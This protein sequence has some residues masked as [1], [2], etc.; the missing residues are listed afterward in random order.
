MKKIVLLSVAIVLLSSCGRNALNTGGEL[1]GVK[2]ASFSEPA[3]YG[4]VLIK[5]GSFE[6]GPAESDS[7]WGYEAD[8]KGVSFESFWMDETEITNAKYRQFVIWVRDSLIRTRLADPEY[9]G[10]DRFM[11][12]EDRY[13]DPVTPHLDWSR[14]IP[15]RPNEDELRAIESV[16]FIHPV[17]GERGLDPKQMNFKYEWYDHT[18]EAMRRNNLDPTLRERNT[19]IPLDPY[20]VIMISKDTAY[21]DDDGNIVNETITRPL[22][23]EFDFL[24]TRI[25]NIYP[26]ETVWVNDFKNAYNEPYLRMYFNHPGYDEYPVVGVSWEQATAFCVWRTIILKK[27]LNLPEGQVIQDFRLPTEGEWEYAARAGKSENIYPWSIEGLKDDKDCFMANFKPGDGNYT[28]DGHLITARVASFSPNEFGLYDMAG[29]VA[30]WTSTVFFESGPRQMSDL[31][32]ELRYNAAIEDP[33]D[34][35]KKVVRGGSFK[36]VAQFIR[37]DMRTFEYQNETRSYIGFRCVRT[38]IG[39]SSSKRGKK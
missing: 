39:F 22:S 8:P 11:I 16:Y 23:S 13:G 21:I 19:D 17:T 35:K 1:V 38:N 25:V 20:E 12:T 9:G 36:D 26:D 29:N 27:S 30:E 6:M 28:E 7:I 14:P 10:D 31:N 4:M 5:R 37:S 34:M 18:A 32:P 24:H 33:Y 3:P 2:S 15:R